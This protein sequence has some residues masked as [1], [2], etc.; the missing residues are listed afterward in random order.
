VSR[1]RQASRWRE[2]ICGE[3]YNLDFL[4]D[5]TTKMNVRQEVW[6]Y[7]EITRQSVKDWKSTLFRKVSFCLNIV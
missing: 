5:I 7:V 1:L 3:A 4:E 2:A 6:K